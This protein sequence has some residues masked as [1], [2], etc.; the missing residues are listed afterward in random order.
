MA[1]DWIKVE[2]CTPDKPEIGFISRACDVTPEQA[3]AA[4]FRLWAYLDEQ[5]ADGEVKFLSPEDCDRIGKL[6]GLG[7]ALSSDLGCGW[8][9]FHQAGA[10]IVNWDRHN[11]NNAKKRALSNRRKADW[12]EREA[13]RKRNAQSVTFA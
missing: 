3:F 9:T 13:E 7:N 2:K 10:S 6:P 1:G 4:F 8:V 12:R 5:T 11:G